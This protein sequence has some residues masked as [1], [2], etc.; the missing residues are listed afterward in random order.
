MISYFIFGLMSAIAFWRWADY[1]FDV[2]DYITCFALLCGGYLSFIFLCVLW[3]AN[4]V[5][6]D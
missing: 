1:T 3:L 5:K 4:N 6:H 2:E